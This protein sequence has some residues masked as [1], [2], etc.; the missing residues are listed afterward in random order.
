MS[1]SKS[2]SSFSNTLLM[3][4]SVCQLVGVANHEVDLSS[5]L[6][7]SCHAVQRRQRA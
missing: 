6:C 7:A 2:S 3:G 1:S 5:N 4:I